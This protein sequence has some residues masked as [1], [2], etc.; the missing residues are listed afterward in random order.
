MKPPVID[1][2]AGAGGFTLGAYRSGFSTALAVDND[3]DLSWSFPVNFPRAQS[4]LADVSRISPRSLLAKA[5]I[6]RNQTFG[7]VGGPP[8]QG[9][10]A[11]GKRSPRDG[12]NLLVRDFFRFVRTLKPAFFIM[13]NVPGILAEPFVRDLEE[14]LDSISSTY[15]FVGPLRLNAAHFGAATLR[16]RAIVIGY[17]VCLMERFSET[18]IERLKAE[19]PTSVFEA[20]HDLPAPDS[21]CRGR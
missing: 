20:I 12:R 8:C 7:I 15:E 10:S 9:F 21:W 2:F 19:K 18:E 14:E 5:G 4:L 1:L 13:E 11:I 6:S 16:T 3:A 17:K